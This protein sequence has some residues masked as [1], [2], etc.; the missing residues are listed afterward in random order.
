M[1]DLQFTLINMRQ[2]TKIDVILH[3]VGI[4]TNCYKYWQL[5]RAEEVIKKLQYNKRVS[6]YRRKCIVK[7]SEFTY[8][9]TG[10]YDMYINQGVSPYDA[11]YEV[12]TEFAWK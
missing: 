9:F 7:C 10:E 11:W 1:K 2:L 3:K 5:P 6:E 12:M 4:N 8:D